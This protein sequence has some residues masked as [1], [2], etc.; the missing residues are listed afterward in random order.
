M[1]S[2]ENLGLAVLRGLPVLSDNAIKLS[3]PRNL[4]GL[5]PD[6]QG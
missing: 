6:L 2:G 4:E 3:L 1:T 5:K